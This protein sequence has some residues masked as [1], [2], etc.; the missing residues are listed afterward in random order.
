M[1][2][3]AVPRITLGLVSLAV[4]LLMGFDMVLKLFPSDADATRDVR[5]RVANSLAI[6]AA[7]LLQASDWRAV[8]RTL[9]AVQARDKEHAIFNVL[10]FY[11]APTAIVFCKTRA[12]VNHL[13]GF[14][15]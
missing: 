9:A 3:T 15:G 11:E 5:T 12:N 7:A 10:R 8:D 1:K 4:V 13:F 2:L 6:Q 14:E